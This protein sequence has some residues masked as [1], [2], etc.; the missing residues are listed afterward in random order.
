[1]SKTEELTQWLNKDF[2]KL[3][4]QMDEVQTTCNNNDD[5]VKM[6]S[7]IVKQ[8]QESENRNDE[9]IKKLLTEIENLATDKLSVDLYNKDLRKQEA[10]FE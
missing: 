6:Y 8:L 2:D 9:F 10:K 5:Q 4:K 7:H 3:T 1:M